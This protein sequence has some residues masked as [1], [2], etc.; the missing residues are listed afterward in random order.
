MDLGFAV[1]KTIKEGKIANRKRNIMKRKELKHRKSV[2]GWKIMLGVLLWWG[3]GVIYANNVRITETVKVVEVT[4]GVATLEM[5]LSWENSWRDDYNWDAVWVFLKHRR[6]NGEWQPVYFQDVEHTATG[7]C[8]V[9][10]AKT[11]G[12]ITGVFVY[13]QSKGEKASVSAKLTLKWD[14]GSGYSQADFDNGRVFLYPQAIEMVHIPSGSYYLGDGNSTLCFSDGAGDPLIVEDEGV[15]ALYQ[16]P[17]SGSVGTAIRLQENYPKGYRSFYVMKYEVSQGQYT[18]FLNKLNRAQQEE[19]L[20]A[21]HL[22]GLAAGNYV[23]G[24]SSQPTDR[25][26]IVLKSK[27]EA[28]PYVFSHNLNQNAVYGEDGDGQYIACNYLSVKDMLAYAAWA[29]LRPMSELEYERIC[30]P[31]PV[32][33]PLPGEYVWNTAAGVVGVNRV[34]ASGTQSEAADGS[35]NVNA[36][37]LLAEGGPVRCGIFARSGSSQQEAGS[38]YWGV[39]EMSGNVGELVANVNNGSFSREQQG[40]GQFST[41]LWSSSAAGYGIRGGSF[42]DAGSLLRISDRSQSSGTITLWTERSRTTGFRLVYTPAEEPG[43]LL[44]GAISLKEKICPGETVTIRSVAPAEMQGATVTLNYSW[45]VK[46]GSQAWETIPGE[47]GVSLVYS[48][49]KADSVY[50][51]K[52]KVSCSFGEAEALSE[53]RTVLTPPRILT[54]PAN[55][56]AYCGLSVSVEA[57]GESLTYQWQNNQADIEGAVGAVY[58]KDPTGAEDAGAYR[59]RVTGLCGEVYSEEAD[60]QVDTLTVEILTDSRDAQQYKARKMPDGKVWM[61]EDLRF[62]NCSSSDFLNYSAVSVVDR[63]APGYYGVCMESTEPGAGKLYNWQAAVNC[64]E[65]AS[66]SSFSSWSLVRG[67][68][69]EGWHL[70]Q[71]SDFYYLYNALCGERERF[72]PGTH[73]FKV[74]LGGEAAYGYLT[75]V[76]RVAGYWTSNQYESN[77][78]DYTGANYVYINES[79]VS[80]YGDSYKANGHAVRCIKD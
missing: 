18:A 41:S 57:V 24:E 14:C 49:M 33:T 69:P 64:E 23:F 45:S 37:H 54:Q 36:D 6:G 1:L 43:D 79:Y 10:G 63:V 3:G 73:A 58:V 71:Q 76:G 56:D 29:G 5:E 74:V 22:A 12:K 40:L 35:S 11:G 52:R 80:T 28:K 67:I 70:P 78:N 30:R 15:L 72:Y 68:C 55:D 20:G 8:R 19:L 50:Q 32:R 16:R 27:E 17:E 59:C 34:S 31:Y 25:N 62:G 38:T 44:A 42:A 46:T 65:G 39:M 2:N 66:G 75:N 61:V 47:T 4:G 53:V 48:D 26:G 77:Y 51:F 21:S 13:P 9:T 7:D 60:I